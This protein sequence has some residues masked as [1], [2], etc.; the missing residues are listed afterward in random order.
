VLNLWV[1]FLFPLR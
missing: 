1:F